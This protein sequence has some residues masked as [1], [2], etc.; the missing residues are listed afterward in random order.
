M[1]ELAGEGM[2]PRC[3]ILLYE[4]CQIGLERIIIRVELGFNVRMR[5]TAYNQCYRQNNYQPGPPPFQ[6][7]KSSTQLYPHGKQAGSGKPIRNVEH[8]ILSVSVPCNLPFRRTTNRWDG[9]P[10]RATP[11]LSPHE[12]GQYLR[13][14]RHAPF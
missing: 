10:N 6:S 2:G 4:G 12:Y 8:R 9:V 3:S 14:Q 1:L 5:D 7:Q 13:L 11:V